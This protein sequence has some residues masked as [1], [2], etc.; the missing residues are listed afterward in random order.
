MPNDAIPPTG[1]VSI[2]ST[3]NG[4]RQRLRQERGTQRLLRIVDLWPEVAGPLLAAHSRP[5]A[6]RANRLVVHVTSPVWLQELRFR[7]EALRERL[8]AAL[9]DEPV[10]ELRFRIGAIVMPRS[11]SERC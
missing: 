4:L 6:L 7:Q 11:V 3:I 8:N 1:A 10:A 9:E 5:S 2:G